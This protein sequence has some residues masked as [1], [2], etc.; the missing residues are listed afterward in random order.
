MLVNL[1]LNT[2]R[3]QSLPKLENAQQAISLLEVGF[4]LFYV[5]KDNVHCGLLHI[6]EDGTIY[7]FF[8]IDVV[9]DPSEMKKTYECEMRVVSKK[10]LRA[11]LFQWLT[12]SSSLAPVDFS[13]KVG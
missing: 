4:S 7:D 13:L 1:T 2:S 6:S 10:A 11:W 12:F 5:D 8:S 9:S 3:F